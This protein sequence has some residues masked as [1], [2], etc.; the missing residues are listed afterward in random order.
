MLKRAPSYPLGSRVHIFI[1]NS[2]V[3]E[4]AIDNED[5]MNDVD[6]WRL[7]DLIESEHSA[8][9]RTR[10]VC[11]SSHESMAFV[12]NAYQ[13]WPPGAYTVVANPEGVVDD[14]VQVK[15]LEK[16]NDCI[17]SPSSG[18]DVFILVNGGG[19]VDVNSSFSKLVQYIIEFSGRFPELNLRCEVWAWKNN[20]NHLYYS[21][22][23]N[24]S[25]NGDPILSIVHLDDFRNEVTFRGKAASFQP[26][27][28]TSRVS[29]TAEVNTKQSQGQNHSYPLKKAPVVNDNGYLSYLQAARPSAV[30]SKSLHP[31]MAA[32][33][34]SQARLPPSVANQKP[35]GVMPTSLHTLTHALQSTK[36]PRPPPYALQPPDPYA[37]ILAG[38]D[39]HPPGAHAPSINLLARKLPAPQVQL[40]QSPTS[41][42]VRAAGI[43]SPTVKAVSLP[44]PS[45]EVLSWP[46][47]STTNQKRAETTFEP[48][49][50]AKLGVFQTNFGWL[51]VDA[52]TGLAY[53]TDNLKLAQKFDKHS[54]LIAEG[55]EWLWFQ[56]PQSGGKHGGRFFSHDQQEQLL[57]AGAKRRAA[58]AKVRSLDLKD[59]LKI[60][61]FL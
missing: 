13:S 45:K 6:I 1:D 4:N 10:V 25:S 39:T 57:L 24:K 59:E 47:A 20:F 22:A 21:W 46:D 61:I 40:G 33:I 56:I 41:L 60:P 11:G 44:S 14:K 31:A 17:I 28:G 29:H 7:L 42:P 54:K 15:M 48:V 3:F 27:E 51:A 53:N 30:H 34:H 58:I 2:D 49:E 43:S 9:V 8:G 50:E 5:Q 38:A 19:H 32:P 18:T 12:W 55:T 36:A 52:E 37:H 16:L 26:L 23:R 35:A